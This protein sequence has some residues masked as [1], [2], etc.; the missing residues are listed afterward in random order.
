MADCL[1]CKNC[2]R[3]EVYDGQWGRFIFDKRCSANVR[4]IKDGR[5]N[6]WDMICDKLENGKP[7]IVP[8]TNEDKR[9]Y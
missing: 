4:I 2:I 1:N 8:M 3:Q 7:K 9:K 6:P 5:L